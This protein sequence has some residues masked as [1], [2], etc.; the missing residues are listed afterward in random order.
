MTIKELIERL[1]E[2]PEDTIVLAFD[3]ETGE[4]EDITGF[5]FQPGDNKQIISSLEICTD[6]NS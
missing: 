6:D 3:G 4:M 2:Y 5:L 1:K